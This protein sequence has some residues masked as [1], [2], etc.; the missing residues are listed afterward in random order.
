M[1]SQAFKQDAHSS[2]YFGP[3]PSKGGSLIGVKMRTGE[4]YPRKALTLNVR[5]AERTDKISLRV[6]FSTV[7][8]LGERRN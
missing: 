6:L 2:K 4:P 8:L 7:N 1:A 5:I 3:L